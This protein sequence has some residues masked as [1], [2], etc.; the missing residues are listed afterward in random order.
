MFDNPFR[1]RKTGSA[2][3]FVIQLPPE[4]ITH[5]QNL[6]RNL[7]SVVGCCWL[8]GF[9]FLSGWCSVWRLLTFSKIKLWNRFFFVASFFLLRLNNFTLLTFHVRYRLQCTAHIHI[10]LNSLVS[11]SIHWLSRP[12]NWFN[13]LWAINHMGCGAFECLS[14]FWASSFCSIH[15]RRKVQSSN[16]FTLIATSSF[17]ISL[18][19]ELVVKKTF[20][21][22]LEIYKLSKRATT[23]TVTQ[24]TLWFFRIFSKKNIGTR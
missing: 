16:Y 20:F 1:V 15:L 3:L 24:R 11:S 8:C 18:S 21:S 19:F 2:G 23:L 13:Q 5:T 7:P 4:K 22:N 12:F 10:H 17:S 9:I 14:L 6:S